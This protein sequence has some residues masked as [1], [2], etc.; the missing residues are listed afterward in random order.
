MSATLRLSDALRGHDAIR[1]ALD[2]FLDEQIELGRDE[3]ERDINPPDARARITLAR[4]WRRRLNV[5]EEKDIHH[6][7]QAT[8]RRA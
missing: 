4:E 8:R 6:G 1:Q 5:E 7:S 2:A 3:L